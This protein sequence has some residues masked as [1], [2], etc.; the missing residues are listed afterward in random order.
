MVMAPTRQPLRGRRR[1]RRRVDEA[2]TWLFA[3]SGCV[4]ILEGP[5][6]IGKTHFLDEIAQAGALSRAHIGRATAAAGHRVVPLG[7]LLEAVGAL[8]DGLRILEAEEEI[9]WLI[10][11]LQ[12][13]LERHAGRQPILIV[14]DDLQWADVTTVAAI[15]VLSTRLAHLPIAWIVALRPGE[16]SQTLADALDRMAGDG[17]VRIHLRPLNLSAVKDMVSDLLGAPPDEDLLVS[18]NAGAQGVPFWV[19]ELLAAAQS[20]DRI[21]RAHGHAIVQG[22]LTA[23]IGGEVRERLD[24]LSP[25]ARE[26]LY[27]AAI[28]GRRMNVRALQRMLHAP[29][30][31]LLVP[32]EEV[33]GTGILIEDDPQLAFRHDLLRE[34]VLGTLPATARPALERQAAN[35]LL[36]L[37]AAPVEVALRLTESAEPGDDEAID[38]IVRAVQ[39]LSSSDPDTAAGL[40]RRAL[41]LTRTDDPRRAAL[42]SGT[43]VLLHAAGRLD[44]AMSFAETAVGELLSPVAESSVHFAIASMFTISPDLRAAANR[45]AL[46]LVG[47]PQNEQ[48]RHHTGLVHNLLAA[49]HQH[50]A[51]QLLAEHSRGVRAAGDPVT[52]LMVDLAE[53]GI[54]YLD[55]RYAES[56]A[57]IEQAGAAAG[58]GVPA[59]MAQQWR[60]ELLSMTDRLPE[61]LRISEQGLRTAQRESQA[62]VVLWWEQ[63]RGRQMTLLGHYQD[64]IAMLEVRVRP[65]EIHPGLGVND[66]SALSALATAARHVGDRQNLARCAE[67]ATTALN[68]GTW[69]LRRNASWVLAQQA[70]MT[71]NRAQAHGHLLHLTAH[72]GPQEALLPS[73]PA[74]LTDQPHLVRLALSVDD[75]AM[76]HRAVELAE[77]RATLNPGSR[78]AAGAAHHAR[79][80]LDRDADA[81]TEAVQAY[82]DSGRRPALA[83]ALEDA[84]GLAVVPEQAIALLGEA[85]ELAGAMD[86]RWDEARLRRRLRQLGVRRRL[87]TSERPSQG[88][89]SLTMSELA[90]VR[91]IT[92]GMTNREAAESL[93][94]SPHT[95]GSHLRHVFRKLNINSRVELARIAAQHSEHLGSLK[96]SDE[97][98]LR[99]ST[100]RRM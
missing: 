63:W 75:R 12:S 18:L 47:L 98:V 61:G 49:G 4:V 14:I 94:L 27:A 52:L 20:A 80:L 22:G 53:A 90:V 31:A 8:A 29:A 59:V 64:A 46:A 56:L 65:G 42:I 6:G 73:F 95:V 99:T 35:V 23:T 13:S 44:E 100:D 72:L 7:A 79:G 24:R 41:E 68:H 81:L 25:P 36:E 43:A 30:T 78:S 88:W 17:A 66:A 34:G 76:A 39:A 62:W 82:R 37:G 28:L 40:A 3:G 70:A 54:L 71:G 9:Y 1:E 5:A 60:T 84:A 74:D 96:Q 19:V 57:L 32:L 2:L 67:I 50:E 21:Q 16:A 38:I 91:A 58:S 83:S 97:V 77:E 87:I 69:E 92:G 15:E 85:L 26:L 48:A 51:R 45:R 55:G 11:S 10:A 86:A 93:H 89:P 33:L